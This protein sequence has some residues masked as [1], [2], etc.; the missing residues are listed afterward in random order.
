ML[1]N[2]F[3]FTETNTAVAAN[4]YW[5]IVFIDVVIAINV[6]NHHDVISSNVNNP[7]ILYSLVLAPDSRYPKCA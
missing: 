5:L 6:M 1:A 2:I 7:V 3:D 4:I